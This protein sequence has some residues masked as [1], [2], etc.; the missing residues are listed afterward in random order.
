MSEPSN[1]NDAR[2]S[3]LKWLVKVVRKT[4][5][6]AWIF[7]LAFL[8]T[9]AGLAIYFSNLPWKPLRVVLALAF[10]AFGVW[11]L[12][13]SR[14]WRMRAIFAGLFLVVLAWWA[15]IRPPT[16]RVWRPEVAIMPRAIIHSDHVQLLNCRNFNYRSTDDFTVRY[17][18]RDVSLA[19]LVSVDFYISY[20]GPARFVGH[21]F[22]SF[23]FDNASPVCISI[24]M[25]P[26]VGQGFSVIGSLFKQYQLIYV[27]GDERD[28]V[29]VRTNFRHERV[30]LYHIRGTPEGARKLFQAYLDRIN[31]LADHPEFYHLLKNSCTVNIVR[32]ANTAG[33]NWVIDYRL[34]LNGLADRFLYEHGYLDTSLPFRELRRRSQINDAAE[35]SDD[36]PNFSDRIR[37]AL[38]VLQPAH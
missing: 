7:F 11:A 17:E 15:S 27:V 28:L 30:Y 32:Y 24:E 9:W 2:K 21:T 13:A 29:R 26:T 5:K 25:R 12:L 14:N 34:R 10:M 8:V 6:W 19:H 35:T 20:W 38:P 36:A 18:N 1:A 16:G 33:K 4:C 31:E 23:C 37:A 22:V 3:P